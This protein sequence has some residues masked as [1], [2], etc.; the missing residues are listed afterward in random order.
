M[1]GAHD[2]VHNLGVKLG[3]RQAL[4]RLDRTQPPDHHVQRPRPQPSHQIAMCALDD[5]HLRF[6]GGC[7]QMRHHLRHQ[8]GRDRGQRAHGDHGTTA[9][10]QLVNTVQPLLQGG[11][12]CLGEMPEH[13]ALRGQGHTA[14]VALQQNRTQ[15]FLKVLERARDPG[16]GQVQPLGSP[17]QTALPDNF[18]K[19]L[20]VAEFDAWVNHSYQI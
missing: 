3:E 19:A 20:D 5:M 12:G 17:L 6:G 8:A 11:H 15:R 16:L 9:A 7:C 10:C 18:D 13:L 14:P 2:H 1:T 4:H